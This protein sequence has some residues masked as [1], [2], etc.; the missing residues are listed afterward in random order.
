[1]LSNRTLTPLTF[2]LKVKPP[3][4]LVDL[5]H[6]MTEQKARVLETDYHTLI[7]AHNIMVSEF[8]FK[9]LFKAVF[10]D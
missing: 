9:F 5:G 10:I 4:V 1:M 2:R 7:P 6:S 8:A 3:F